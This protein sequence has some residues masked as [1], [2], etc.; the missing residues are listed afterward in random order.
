MD[1]NDGLTVGKAEGTLL[2]T[3]EI[4]GLLRGNANP[5]GYVQGTGMHWL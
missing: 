4:V 2:G 3:G 1:R 5:L